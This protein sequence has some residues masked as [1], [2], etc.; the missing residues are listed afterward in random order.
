MAHAARLKKI[1]E[2]GKKEIVVS[3]VAHGVIGV[4]GFILLTAAGAFVRIPLP[5]TPVP[6]TLQTFFVL[7][8]GAV[9][10][11]KLG[12]LS[13]AGYVTLGMFGLPIFAGAAGGALYILGP[14]GGYLVGFIVAAYVVGRIIRLK[15]KASFTWI[16]LAMLAGSLI[17]YIFGVT[18]LAFFLNVGFQKA[19][20][21]GMLP[22][23][24]GD[25][26]KLL[27]AALIYK[28]IEKRVRAIYPG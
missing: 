27:A 16:V 20:A 5:F 21:L 14:T 9:L 3:P 17:I 12:I 25:I 18:R 24:P 13:Q 26:I 1:W 11:R 22:F 8:S 28:G 4:F 15:E 2:I 23:I 6:I 10:G 7:L 19:L